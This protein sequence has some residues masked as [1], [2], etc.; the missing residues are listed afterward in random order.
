[1]QSGANDS[2]LTFGRWAHAI[3]GEAVDPRGNAAMEFAKRNSDH[4]HTFHYNPQKLIIELGGK[5]FSAEEPEKILADFNDSS[6]LLETTTLGFVEILFCCRALRQS[7]RR[8]ASLLYTEPRRYNRPFHSKVVH[9]R[10]FEL[11]EEVEMFTGVPGNARL[12]LPERPVKA[13]V[14]LGYEGQ[15]LN[16]LLEQTGLSPS[17]CEFVFGVPAFHP[18]W[19]MDA[20]ANNLRILKGEQMAG[21]LNFCG[22]QNPLSAYEMLGRIYESCDSQRIYVSVAPIGTK[23]HGIGAALFLSEH[24]DV[25]VVYDNPKRK[26][27]RSQN[28][29]TWHLFNVEF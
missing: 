3:V 18:G 15:R 20:F 22:A 7:Q 4:L 9:R 11:S 23:P 8:T 17:K 10:D 6:V 13:V 19:E 12:L 29:G 24:S 1:M 25:G 14:F 5:S 28:V 26:K 21:R 16:R 27:E 2:E